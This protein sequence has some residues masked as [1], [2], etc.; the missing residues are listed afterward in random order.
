MLAKRTQKPVISN[1]TVTPATLVLTKQNPTGTVNV[2][3]TVT[4]NRAVSQVSVSPDGHSTQ[5]VSQGS[6]GSTYQFSQTF[7]FDDYSPWPAS[8]TIENEATTTLNFIA[9]ASDAALN[10]A[11]AKSFSVVVKVQDN[12]SPTITS[13]PSNPRALRLGM[14][15]TVVTALLEDQ[16][17]FIST[18]PW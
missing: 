11:T 16:T 18:R 2:S 6:S 12:V 3:M 5:L 14:A 7:N 15:K 1:L 17:T 13:L 8:L 10:L 9:S 4:D